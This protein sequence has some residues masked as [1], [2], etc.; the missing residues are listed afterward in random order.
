MST[1]NKSATDEYVVRWYE[2]SDLSDF[3]ALDRAVFR[4]RRDDRW[5]KW[6]YVDNPYVDHVPVF[7][8]ER[9]D[10]IVG[11]RPFLAFRMRAGSETVLALQPADTMVHPEHRRRGLFTRMTQHA[12][13]HYEDGDPA[14]FFNFPNQRSRPGY[15]KLGWQIVGERETYYRVQDPS[16]LFGNGGLRSHLLDRLVPVTSK[17]Y[18]ARRPR[19]AGLGTYSVEQFPGVQES[20][21]T[22]LYESNPPDAVHALR[23]ET[24]Y[25]WRFTSPAWERTTYVVSRA[26]EPVAGA[27]VRTRTTSNDVTVT[28]FA[29]IV[30]LVGSERRNQA[31]VPLFE[32]VIDDHAD[33]DLLALAKGELPHELVSKY[34]FVSDATPPLSWMSDFDCRL[35]AL[36]LEN[37][38]SV[39]DKR[40]SQR[41]NWYV[42]FAERDTA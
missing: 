37:R 32:R 36:P 20:I 1:P 26:G 35:V 16:A 12:I 17:L 24:F 33:S 23:D 30:P 9:N 5:F 4:R 28:Q 19:N 3:L 41:S 21:L 11:A 7:V 2:G 8:V 15:L 10:D 38:W 42:S 40:L 14:F 34:G 39:G 29:D 27:I 25:R 22:D 6:K 13:D 18:E 31:L